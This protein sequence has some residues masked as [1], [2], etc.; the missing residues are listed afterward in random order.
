MPAASMIWDDRA[1]TISYS[2]AFYWIVQ[3]FKKDM[4]PSPSQAICSNNTKSKSTIGK[5]SAT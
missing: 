1:R 4:F 2:Y 3:K 5:I